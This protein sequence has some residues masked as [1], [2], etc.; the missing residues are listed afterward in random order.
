MILKSLK[1]RIRNQYN[2]SVAEE[3]YSDLW[4]RTKLAIVSV[5]SDRQ[6][7]SN[8]F[9]KIQEQLEDH[10]AIQLLQSNTEYF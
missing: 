3:D 9:V 2:V 1:E 4:P 7:L 5:S 10:G 8:L 6:V